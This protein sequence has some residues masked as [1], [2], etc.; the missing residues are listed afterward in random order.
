MIYYF[1]QLT[2]GGKTDSVRAVLAE[3]LSPNE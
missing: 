2:P 3:R 1:S